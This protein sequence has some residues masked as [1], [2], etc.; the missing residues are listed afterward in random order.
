[1]AKTS[2]SRQLRQVR[3]N[4]A[5]S[6]RLADENTDTTNRT[7]TT[8]RIST[9]SIAAN[10]TRISTSS[11]VANAIKAKKNIDL[12][13]SE[14]YESDISNADI[15]YNFQ[16]DIYDF[17]EDD[18]KLD[19]ER[20]NLIINHLLAASAASIEKKKHPA[21]YLGNS[22]RTKQRKNKMLRE[23]AVET[24]K[25][26]QFFPF[27][28]SMTALNYFCI[29]GELIWNFREKFPSKSLLNDELVSLQLAAYLHSVKFKV[30]PE[31]V[32]SYIE[33]KILPQLNVESSSISIR[34]ARRWMQKLGF[35][36]KRHQQGVYVDGH[37][38]PDVVA[39]RHIFFQKVAEFDQFMS[40]WHDEGCEFRI[41]PQLSNGEKEHVWVTHDETTFY[42]YDGPCAV[43]C[44][45][46]EQP[47]RKKGLGLGIHISDFMTEMIGLLKDEEEE[48]CVTMD[49]EKLHQQV[50]R[51]I[52]IFERTH[53]GCIDIFAFNN[54]TSHISFVED[55]LLASR[56]NLG[57][58]G[59]V[60]KIRDTVWNGCHQ[61]MI[62]EEDHF[63]YDKKTKTFI[64]LCGK[65]K[66]IKWVLG[67]RELWREGMPLEC[68]SCKH[69]SSSNIVD[70]CACRL[71]TNQPDFFVQCGQIQEEIE[72]C[73]HK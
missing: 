54:A 14:E 63:V 48:A 3:A 64:N 57:P 1:M 10:V 11:T 12:W 8:T 51:V 40:K 19:S 43:W 26:S 59:A 69:K 22:K 62:I 16:E 36:Y 20:V 7:S 4:L 71:M 56:M 41:F 32:K 49:T 13:S 28:N 50:K 33:Q 34:T 30:N 21:I 42:A 60:P 45:E 58:D 27:T 67:N 72:S 18:N 35:Y 31:T 73:G 29:K 52:K 23:A 53:S 39:Y 44:P 55:A 47:L 65:P 37:E 61:S 24:S 66:E 9:S 5:Y 70:C 38:R 17:E 25:I 2:K 46:E 68:T 15:A 6:A